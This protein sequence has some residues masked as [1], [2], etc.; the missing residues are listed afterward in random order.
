MPPSATA[1][2]SK[3]GR[4]KWDDEKLCEK[5][6]ELEIK[7]DWKAVAIIAKEI[8]A[9]PDI[10]IS[11]CVDISKKREKDITSYRRN[12][13]TKTIA[14]DEIEILKTAMNSGLEKFGRDYFRNL[15]RASCK[16]E[17]FDKK[18]KGRLPRLCRGYAPY[19]I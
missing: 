9:R 1:R 12:A 13:R 16:Q 6:T 5:S 2:Y 11:V 4:K 14:D 8:A 10:D 7:K 3:S 17:K 18:F 19:R 15:V